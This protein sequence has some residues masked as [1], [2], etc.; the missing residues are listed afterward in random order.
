MSKKI[1]KNFIIASLVFFLMACLEGCMFPTKSLFN[2]WYS[3]IMHVPPAQLKAFMYEFFPRI[4]SHISLVGWVSSALMGMLY[5]ITP[6]IQGQEKFNKTLC[7]ANFWM[8]IVGILVLCAG[9]HIVGSVGL[10]AGYTHGTSEFTKAVACY[11]PVIWTGSF[12]LLVSAALFLYNILS[13]LC[14]KSK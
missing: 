6:Q 5:F 12:A 13:C 4:H 14:S 7:Y 10:S 9:W 1:A 11:K 3:A 2:I 8:H